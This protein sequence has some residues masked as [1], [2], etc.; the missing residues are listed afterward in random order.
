MTKDTI[1]LLYSL[2]LAANIG[3]DLAGYGAYF[4]YLAVIT[5]RFK[6]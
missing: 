6:P 5:R 1:N 2:F 3:I 4:V